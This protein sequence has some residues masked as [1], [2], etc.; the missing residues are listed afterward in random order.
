[1]LEAK[2]NVCVQTINCIKDIIYCFLM[3]YL[4]LDTIFFARSG[5][6][7]SEAPYLV[8]TCLA[9]QVCVPLA[10]TVV[11]H[12]VSFVFPWCQG[13]VYTLVVPCESNHPAKAPDIVTNFFP[14]GSLLMLCSLHP[15]YGGI[16]RLL[17]SPPAK[18]VG[19]P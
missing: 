6:C 18:Y 3:T 12:H 5:I 8:P 1:M 19:S 14:L 15:Q 4:L 2:K 16:P 9:E 7:L 17:P 13:Q 10:A 11:A